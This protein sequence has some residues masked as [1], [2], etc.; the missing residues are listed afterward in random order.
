MKI[1]GNFKEILRRS[2]AS[3]K[4]IMQKNK[5]GRYVRKI[6]KNFCEKLGGI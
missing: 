5:F 1:R 6:Y 4:K 3:L 2:E